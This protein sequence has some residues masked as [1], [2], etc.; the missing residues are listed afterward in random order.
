M[1]I[2]NSILLGIGLA[3]DAFSVSIANCL[4]EPEMKK[5][6]Q[7]GIA[8][9]YAFFQFLMPLIGWVCVHTIISLFTWFQSFIPWI[10]LILL[11]YIGIQMILESKEKKEESDTKKISNTELLLQGIAT[12][13]DA[14]SVGFAIA[15]YNFIS[16]FLCS[17]IIA[18]VTFILC[19]IGM[20][21]G[22]IAGEKL[23]EKAPL[24]GGCI[25]IGIG[26]NIFI[27]SF[28]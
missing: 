12:S 25:L 17:L 20:R 21:L 26:L 11:S 3:M 19:I 23:S 4:K 10:A 2:I 28:F 27:Q 16:A 22:K 1:F 15:D 7:I 6:R 13:I 9:I 24:V 8:F 14:L 5:K 18:I